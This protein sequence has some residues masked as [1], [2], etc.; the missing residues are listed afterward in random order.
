ARRIG[1]PYLEFTGLAYRAGI[2]FFRPGVGAVERGR[3]AVELAQQ[4]GWTDEP[5]VGFA[6]LHVGTVL[7]HQGRLEEAEPWIQQAERTI[8]A[9]AEPAVGMAVR[10]MRG[11]LELSG[12]R[13]ADALAAFEAGD[14]LAGRLAEPSLLVLPIRCLLVQTLVRLGEIER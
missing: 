4:H 13:D 1:R 5:A 10:F 9:D 2:E 6:S 8:R 11:V 7:V 12:G 3:R 14:R